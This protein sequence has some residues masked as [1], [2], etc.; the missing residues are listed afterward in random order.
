M[1]Y[2]IAHYCYQMNTEL[3]T[4]SF[5]KALDKRKDEHS[6]MKSEYFRNSEIRIYKIFLFLIKKLDYTFTFIL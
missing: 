5:F 4:V 3:S 2:K 6:N 1:F